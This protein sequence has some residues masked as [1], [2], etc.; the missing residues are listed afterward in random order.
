MELKDTTVETEMD[1]TLEEKVKS[2]EGDYY[3]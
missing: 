3:K 1:E 2:K